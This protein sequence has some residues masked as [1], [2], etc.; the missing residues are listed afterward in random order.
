MY[1]RIT[2]ARFDPA[3]YEQVSAAAQEVQAA[4]Q[5]LPG[6]QHIHQGVDRT[7]GSV[8]AVSVWDSEEHA[9]FA[10]EVLGESIGRLRALGVQ[11]EEPE[12]YEIM[13]GAETSG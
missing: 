10:R 13:E 12:I 4:M 6:V 3:S 1:L 8:A 2:R 5:Q 7:T 9:R 11:F